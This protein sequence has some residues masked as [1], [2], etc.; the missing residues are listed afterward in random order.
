MPFQARRLGLGGGRSGG[1]REPQLVL[2]NNATV[3]RPVGA[4]RCHTYFSRNGWGRRGRTNRAAICSARQGVGARLRCHRC[5]RVHS[6]RPAPSQIKSS[7]DFPNLVPDGRAAAPLRRL[8]SQLFLQEFPRNFAD[9]RTS[10]T[11]TCHAKLATL[12]GGKLSRRA[13][14]R[15]SLRGAARC[16]DN[17]DDHDAP[18]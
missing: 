17:D 3:R 8:S 1:V 5:G 15:R 6:R 7:T 13:A 9:R 14:A 10:I 4:S 12:S 16:S 18:V 11:S 2:A